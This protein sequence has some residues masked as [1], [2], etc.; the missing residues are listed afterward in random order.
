[1]SEQTETTPAPRKWAACTTNPPG[2]IQVNRFNKALRN[3]DHEHYTSVERRGIIGKTDG[4]DAESCF[5]TVRFSIGGENAQR[6][7]VRAVQDEIGARYDYT[8]SKAN[9][10][11]I[12][13]D[14]QAAM[15]KLEGARPC[16]DTRETQAFTIPPQLL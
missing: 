16:N 10:N 1:M 5:T 7:D 2:P 15:F 11:Q 13:A 8:V 14:I 4:Y 9:V 6:E 12:L 3:L